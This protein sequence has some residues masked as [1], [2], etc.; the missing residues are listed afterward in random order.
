MRVFLTGVSGF[1]GRHIVDKLQA[2]GFEI[3]ALLRPSSYQ[4][5]LKQDGI[6]IVYGDLRDERVIAKA[7]KKIDVVIHCAATMRGNWDKYYLVNVKS[8]EMLLEHCKSIGVRKFVYISSVIVYDHSTMKAGT[9][10]TEDMPYEQD[11][12]T[13]YSRSKIES[14]KIISKYHEQFGIPTTIL[15]PAAL[16]GSGGQIFPARLGLALGKK[17]YAIIGNGMQLLPLSNVMSVAD[18]VLKCITNDVTNGKC[19]NVVEDDSITQKR[20][21][22]LFRD[23]TETKIAIVKIP[24]T[25]AKIAAIIIEKGLGLIG[26]TSPLRL[27]YLKLCSHQYNYPTQRLKDDLGWRPCDDFKKSLN[28]VFLHYAEKTKP[29]R[30]V[31]T[32]R[33]KVIVPV[34]RQLRVGIVGCG[35]FAETHVSILKRFKNAEVTALCDMNSEARE[36]LAK[37][38]K[39]SK[40]YSDMNEMLSKE[41]ID[42][43]HIL[44]P[45]QSHAELS[46]SAMKHKCHVLVEKPMALTEGE[47][48]EM[49]RVADEHGVKL[50][51]DHNHLF[52]DVM[53]KARI[54]LANATLGRIAY[55]E[56]WYG[57]D[58]SSNTGNRYLQY[59]ARSHWV[60]RMPGALYQNMISHPISLLRDVMDEVGNIKASAKY[61]HVV[62]HMKTDELRVLVENSKMLGS[63]CLSFATSPRYHFLNIYGTKGHL[64]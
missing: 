61:T 60:Y 33:G 54:L 17:V 40:T 28:E 26:K 39:V 25:V 22:E 49:I 1:L 48:K 43:V 4:E 29:K 24:Y 34:D 62:P 53:I 18:A 31:P 14:E 52:D 5:N 13:N 46:I 35:M 50:C 58:Y 51:V 27:P 3:V 2:E 45:A 59:D 57:T 47:A 11:T 55:V 6:Q 19:Y 21:L 56:S 8:T 41:N 30:V 36:A 32:R 64:K 38:F 63:L 12:L 7:L 44:T 10:F 16:Y 20:F 42:V 23:V 37:R 15:R 9:N